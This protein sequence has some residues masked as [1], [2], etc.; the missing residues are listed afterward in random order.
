MVGILFWNTRVT[1]KP[2]IDPHRIS[3]IENII[4]NIVQENK[5][6]IVVLAEFNTQTTALCNKLSLIGRDFCERKSIVENTRVK[7]LADSRFVSAII[8]DSKYY[9]IHDFRLADHH[10]LVGGVHLPSKRNADDRDIQ[11]V[12]GYFINAIKEAEK[13]VNHEKVIMIGDFNVNP[14]EATMTDSSSLH[15]I[16]DS[17]IVERMRSR[18]VYG[19]SRQM[20][21]NPIWNLFGD[22][23]DPKGS[24]YSESGMSC[25]LFWH[26][27]DQV[28]ISADIIK[29]YAKDSLKILT[30]VSGESFLNKHGKPNKTSYSDHLPL[31]FALQ[32]D[33]L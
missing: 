12:G 13:T 16:F 28:I 24:Y 2:K 17:S 11:T 32:E 18:Q 30:G 21:Y 27:F 33:L 15:A 31:F 19:E 7:V 6:D 26:I 23:N 1:T 10:F 8:R 25:K 9:V 4:V 29:A 14:F 5:C 3:H 20:F 22:A